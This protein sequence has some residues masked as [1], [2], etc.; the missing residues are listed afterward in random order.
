MNAFGDVINVAVG[1]AAHVDAAAFHEVNVML[2]DELIN[3]AI[4]SSKK[5]VSSLTRA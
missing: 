3:C 4:Y 5:L 1:Y 2:R